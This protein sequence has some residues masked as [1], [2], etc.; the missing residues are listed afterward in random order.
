MADEA[1]QRKEAGQVG[2]QV[3]SWVGSWAGWLSAKR[4]AAQAWFYRWLEKCAALQSQPLAVR[5][6]AATLVI[7]A[8]IL[9]RW[10]LMGELGPRQVYQ[11]FYPAVVIAGLVGGAAAGTLA[12]A[13]SVLLVVTWISPPQAWA[14][15]FGSVMFVVAGG[16]TVVMT[17][18]LQAAQLRAQQAASRRDSDLR[19]RAI[20][21]QQFQFMAVLSPE[22]RLLEVNDMPLASDKVRREDVIGQPFADTP[23]WR[24]LPEIRAAWPGRLAAAAAQHAPL[25]IDDLYNTAD[26]SVCSADASIQAVRDEND[27]VRFF[28]VQA[29]DTTK[30]KRA[31]NALLESEEQLRLA[32]EVAGLGF[33]D[34]DQRAEK[35]SWSPLMRQIFGV[36]ADDPVSLATYVDL[37][38]PDERAAMIAAVKLSHDPRGDGHYAVEHRVVPR[39]GRIRWVALRA[40]TMFEGDGGARRPVRTV[41]VLL[42]VTERKQSEQQQ[43]RLVAELDHRVKNTLA[44]VSTVVA[45]SRQSEGSTQDFIDAVDGRI[46]SMA[47]A[48]DMLSRNRWRDVALA[49]LVRQQLA[50]YAKND[51]IAMEGCEIRLAP[52]VAQALAMLLHELATNAVKYGALSGAHGRVSVDW[53]RLSTPIAGVASSGSPGSVDDAL[54]ARAV[55]QANV[56]LMLAWQETGGPPVVP[57]ARVGFGTVLIRDIISYELDGTVD[58]A[59]APGGLRCTIV[60]PDIELTRRKAAARQIAGNGHDR[61]EDAVQTAGPI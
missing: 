20:F 57:P 51:R 2:N 11:M 58:L 45:L 42:D 3:G 43:R 7:A 9:V 33:F 24:N 8:A 26:G 27:R 59:F 52:D 40:Q 31:H 21:D 48:H 13:L 14:E 1:H 39:D 30:S 29:H 10:L 36:G 6:F 19:L 56:G 54:P 44:R 53:Q 18:A 12:V 55:D 23:W 34:H 25:L 41:G 15:V 50:P 46:Q 32:I 17:A 22:G 35:L 28:I 47:K 38:H 5:L 61:I 37:I 49:D 16:V 60:I 4:A